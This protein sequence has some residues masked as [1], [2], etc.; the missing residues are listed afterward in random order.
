MKQLG[1]RLHEEEI[2]AIFHE[3]D[4]THE[5]HLSFRQFL[6][7]LALGYLLRVRLHWAGGAPPLSR[8]GSHRLVRL[9][10]AAARRWAS[11]HPPTPTRHLCAQIIPGS[12]SVALSASLG[13]PP[14]RKTVEMVA[15]ERALSAASAGTPPG[16]GEVVTDANE[17][18]EGSDAVGGAEEKKRV[19]AGEEEEHASGPRHPEPT[20]AGD[21]DAERK[22][23]DREG[24]AA[25]KREDGG[26]AGKGRGPGDGVLSAESKRES[27]RKRRLSDAS[28]RLMNSLH[29]KG[30]LA[31]A[32]DMVLEAYVLFDQECRGYITRKELRT[33]LKKMQGQSPSRKFVRCAWDGVGH[34][35]EGRGARI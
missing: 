26:E 16:G 28:F 23:A 3:A 32:F 9:A 7:C 31:R 27:F 5:Q 15:R 18:E 30:D 29:F 11:T 34:A 2:R 19:E 17:G 24:G 25:G 6:L 1:L 12:T 14:D 20:D 22:A 35:G 4:F 33:A 8:T 10:R 21:E 13:E